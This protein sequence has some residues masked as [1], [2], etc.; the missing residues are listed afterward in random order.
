MNYEIKQE[1]KRTIA[2][3][4]LVGPWERTVKQG[5]EQLM[6]WV[7]GKQI[8]GQEWIAVYF[9]NPQQVPPEKLRCTTAIGV[10]PSFV[11]P[12]ASEGVSLSGI[13][14]GLYAVATV[15]VEDHDFTT[16]WR[17]FFNDLLQDSEY[18]MSASPCF[19][20]YLN[21]GA[22]EG[23]WDLRMYVPVQAKPHR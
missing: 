1:Q 23:Y 10:D 7:S 5:F 8:V 18:A 11:V 21:D 2:G 3:F 19:E 15:R 13:D 20:V 22:K 12:P 6:K 17:Q 4:H 14:G 9:D 16:P